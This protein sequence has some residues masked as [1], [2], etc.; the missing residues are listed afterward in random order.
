MPS[1]VGPDLE[2]LV[3]LHS[4]FQIHSCNCQYKYHNQQEKK[5]KTTK[6]N[7]ERIGKVKKLENKACDRTSL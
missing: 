4:L 6:L 1:I 2:V 5:K 7:G 3:N